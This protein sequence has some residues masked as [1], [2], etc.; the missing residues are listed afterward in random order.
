MLVARPGIRFVH[1]KNYRYSTE[2]A[3]N[4]VRKGDG[5]GSGVGVD[6]YATSPSRMGD[7]A[8]GPWAIHVD[9]V[10]LI[11]GL[12]IGTP[13]HCRTPN[14]LPR[15]DVFLEGEKPFGRTRLAKVTRR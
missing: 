13:G 1:D 15:R 6:S 9:N 14:L 5:C 3:I 12:E 7:C 4:Q 2:N 10:D 11:W 8:V